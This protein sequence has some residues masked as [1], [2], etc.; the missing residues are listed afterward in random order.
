[1]TKIYVVY[2]VDY[3]R[4]VTFEKSFKSKNLAELHANDVNDLG[5]SEFWYSAEEVELI[6]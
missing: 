1:M 6:E 4:I 5:Y 2:A 3:D